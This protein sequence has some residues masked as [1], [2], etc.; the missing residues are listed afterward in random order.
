MTNDFFVNLLDM[1]TKWQKSTGPEGVLE[2]YDRNN[3]RV[4]VTPIAGV[5][6]A[7][8]SDAFVKLAHALD[9]AAAK[10][11]IDFVGGL[12]RSSRRA[13]RDATRP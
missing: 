13:S 11:G 9:A 4:S 10:I 2:G 12:R 6:A 7:G 3:R 8:G 5:L 1:N